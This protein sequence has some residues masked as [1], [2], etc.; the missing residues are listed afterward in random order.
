MVHHARF[1]SLESIGKEEMQLHG[2]E[3]K[4]MD[5]LRAIRSLENDI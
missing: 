5:N 1:G 3:S 2:K 4:S